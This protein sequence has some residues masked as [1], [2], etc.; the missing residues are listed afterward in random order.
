[1]TERV[2]DVAVI[3]G[4]PAGLQA[5]KEAFDAGAR[6]LV[7]ERE[8]RL[9]GILKQCIHDGFGVLEYG[10]RLTG[11]EY[12]CRDIA[13]AKQR[14]IPTVT[15]AFVHSL[16]RD[17]E[18]W[19]ITLVTPRDGVEELHCR[20]VVM[21]TGCR[22][23]TDRQVLLQGE[24]PAGIFTAGQ[25]QRLI[26]INGVLPGRN[27]VILGSG[28][29]GLIMAR[30]FTLEGA[31]VLGIYE[32]KDVPSGLTRNIAQ[33]VEDW[34]IPMHLRTTVTEVHGRD[35]VEAVTVCPVDAEGRPELSRGQKVRCDTLV[36]SV[37]LIPED[38]IIWP[39]GLE[40]DERTR[41]PFVNQHRETRLPGL[42]VC[43]NALHVYDLVDYVSECGR[44]A[45]GSAARYCAGRACEVHSLP[46]QASHELLYQV[47]QS[48]DPEAAEPPA[49]FYRVRRAMERAHLTV[50]VEG[51]ELERTALRYCR[52]QEMERFAPARSTWEAITTARGAVRLSV[53]EATHE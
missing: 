42:Y 26:N 14:G 28:D 47:P 40:M 35:R 2:C 46:V 20:S 1:M 10:E 25:A 31:R 5:A 3:G 12:A 13:A 29:I 50:S 24:R 36:L 16:A 45:G 17:G 49:F 19:R 53:E 43:G 33:C 41:G 6:V 30:R 27:V 37:G 4:G 39:L 8:E 22:E 18:A 32:I 23:R 44:A 15:S 38:D 11:P 52:P 51:K 9:G 48:V 21:A 7:V 34:N